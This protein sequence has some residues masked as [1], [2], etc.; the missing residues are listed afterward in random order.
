MK[1]NGMHQGFI[2]KQ[3]KYYFQSSSQSPAESQHEIKS[4]SPISPVLEFQDMGWGGYLPE[5]TRNTMNCALQVVQQFTELTFHKR[6]I[7]E[8]QLRDDKQVLRTAV[9][10]CKATAN[11]L[12]LT[13]ENCYGN[14]LTHF[15]NVME[16]WHASIM[17]V[18]CAVLLNTADNIPHAHASAKTQVEVAAEQHQRLERLL[19]IF[20]DISFSRASELNLDR[21]RDHNPAWDKFNS[22]LIAQGFVKHV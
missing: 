5:S 11:A 16:L 6:R 19:Q 13:L 8:A 1:H 15:N 20:K 14:Q 3:K 22:V 12:V 9:E 21:I 17:S 4:T 10:D 18:V 7:M 2:A